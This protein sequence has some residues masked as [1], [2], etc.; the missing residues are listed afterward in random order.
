MKKDGD[1]VTY[2][3]KKLTYKDV[4]EFVQV[5]IADEPFALEEESYAVEDFLGVYSN[6]DGEYAREVELGLDD[7]GAL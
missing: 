1:H 2:E 7:D 4:P 3:V 5:E 6:S